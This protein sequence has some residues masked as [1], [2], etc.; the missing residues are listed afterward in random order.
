VAGRSPSRSDVLLV[1]ACIAAALALGL[2][3]GTD[4][5]RALIAPIGAVALVLALVWDIRIVVPLLV[6][7]VPFGIK[8]AFGFGNLY[9]A[10]AILIVT[11]VVWV[12]RAPAHA[13]GFSLRFCGVVAAL[14]ILVGVT[15]LSGIQ[16]YEILKHDGPLTMKIIQFVMYSCLLVLVYQMSFSRQA[17]RT[18]FVLMLLSGVAEGLIGALQ[19]L[20]RPGFYV[21]GAAGQHNIFA[22]QITFITLLLVGVVLEARHFTVRLACIAGI[23]VLIFALVFSFS[24]TG[25]IS[26]VVSSLTFLLLPVSRPK[27]F[28]VPAIAA[29]VAVVAIAVVPSAVTARMRDII[30]TATGEHVTLSMKYRVEMWRNALAEFA[31][32]PIIGGGPAAGGSTGALKDNFFIKALA[33]TGLVGLGALLAIIY[34]TL[35]ASW[36]RI[37]E[38][39][40]DPFMR[41]I[42]L[43]FFPAAAGA[44]IVFNLT[45]DLLGMHGFMGTFWIA[46]ALLLRYPEAAPD[47]TPT[48]PAFTPAATA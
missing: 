24:R 13:G 36:Q 45:S 6:V 37:A 48:A 47:V 34:L 28:V 29:V 23:A 7:L 5:G 43:G 26:L 31:A 38:P 4:Q 30:L 8:F 10:T 40:R 22:V 2:I 25:Y 18:I 27:R 21:I 19:W 46:L 3:V 35:R 42:M 15:M 1:G 11:L 16:N 32:N 20:T 39:A 17:I 14:V 44:L 12:A 33:E 41:G 9:L